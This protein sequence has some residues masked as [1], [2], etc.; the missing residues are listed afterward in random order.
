MDAFTPAHFVLLAL[1]YLIGSIPCGL[2]LGRAAGLGDIRATGS[3]NIGAT[4]M[5]RAG[6]KKLGAL[7][8]LC[9]ALKG[10]VVVTLAAQYLPHPTAS[11]L[12]FYGFI[13]AIAHCYPVWLKFRGGK[14]V[15]T[16]LGIIGAVHIALYPE[17]W[18]WIMLFAL[19]W[20]GTFKATR[21]VSLASLVTFIFMPVFTYAL[22]DIWLYPLLLTALVFMRHRSNIARILDGTEHGFSKPSS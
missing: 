1:A 5:V 12:Y 2:L 21:Y 8:L 14:G 10:V 13:T 3:G 18:W 22:Y 20:I 15:A 9:D 17:T 6:G 4:N 19:L 11:L 7:T 16:T